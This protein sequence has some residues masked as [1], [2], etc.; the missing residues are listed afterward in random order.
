MSVDLRKMSDIIT[1][2]NN[3][4]CY[5]KVPADYTQGIDTHKY[6]F[7]TAAREFDDRFNSHVFSLPVYQPN[8]TPKDN[9]GNELKFYKPV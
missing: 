8:A 9:A 6:I 4:F 3:T 5:V 1:S 7:T 2:N